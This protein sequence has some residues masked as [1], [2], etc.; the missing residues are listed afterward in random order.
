MDSYLSVLVVLL[1]LDGWYIVLSFKTVQL[2]WC[3]NKYFD[4]KKAGIHMFTSTIIFFIIVGLILSN[5]NERINPKEKLKQ[6]I[7]ED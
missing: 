1:Y 2:F 4:I 7:V 5:I 6:E 3:K